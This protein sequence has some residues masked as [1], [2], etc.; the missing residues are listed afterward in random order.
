MRP[1]F[2]LTLTMVGIVAMLAFGLHRHSNPDT[3]EIDS[4]CRGAGECAAAAKSSIRNSLAI[5]FERF[6]RLSEIA[7]RA[8]PP[9]DL[10]VWPRKLDARSSA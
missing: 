7:V 5:F 10:L 3:V 2:D 1:H 6:Q 9:P 8:N 4:R